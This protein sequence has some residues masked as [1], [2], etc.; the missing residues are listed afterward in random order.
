MAAEG[1]P[2]AEY[3][4]AIRLIRPIR[5]GFPCRAQCRALLNWVPT[6]GLCVRE[7]W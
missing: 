2:S 6:T 3:L 1:G 4:G 5:V 7:V